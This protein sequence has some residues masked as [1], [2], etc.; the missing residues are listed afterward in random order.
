MTVLRRIPELL[1][2][3]KEL[4]KWL[5]LLKELLDELKKWPW[6]PWRGGDSD[7]PAGP[8]RTTI[9]KHDDA[10][11]R[12]LLMQIRRLA[13]MDLRKWIEAAEELGDD[14]LVHVMRD[15]LDRLLAPPSP[16]R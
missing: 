13:C 9:V 4:L 6:P 10:E 11:G 12:A 7:T 1:K 16:E 3:L 5:P 15:A 2:V 8:P 14:E